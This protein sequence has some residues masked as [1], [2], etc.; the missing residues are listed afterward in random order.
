MI[1][2]LKSLLNVS[3]IANRNDGLPL[4]RKGKVSGNT[5]MSRLDYSLNRT[6]QPFDL[7]KSSQ[8]LTHR[9]L[10]Y[11]FFSVSVWLR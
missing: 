1:A 10:L 2:L 3:G 11:G 4:A 7:R 6:W 9:L 8:K 5:L